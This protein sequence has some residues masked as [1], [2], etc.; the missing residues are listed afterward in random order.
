MRATVVRIDGYQTYGEDEDGV[1]VELHGI[2]NL[3]VG[4]VVEGHLLND[5]DEPDN[6]YLDVYRVWERW[7]K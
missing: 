2:G 7:P 6:F 3:M 4:D 1:I 5:D